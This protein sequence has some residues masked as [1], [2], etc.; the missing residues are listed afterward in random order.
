MT[1]DRTHILVLTYNGRDLL[2]ECLPSI[3]L[4]AARSAVP[5]GV[6]VVDNESTDG[7][8]ELVSQ[9]W[10]GVRVVREQ[11]RGLTSFNRVLTAL[12]EPVVLLLNNDVKLAPSAVAP[13]LRVFEEHDAAL[14]SAQLC[15]SFEG[16]E[17]EGM[18]TRVRS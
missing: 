16:R 6:T 10:P 18:R 1:I 7:S 3:A 4:A 12:D 11:N 15:W 2:A 5:C 17:Y 9:R 14:F 13:L 8:A